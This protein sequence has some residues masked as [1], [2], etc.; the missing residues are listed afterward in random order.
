MIIANKNVLSAIIIFE[1]FFSD[2]FR[3]YDYGKIGNMKHY[4]SKTPPNYDLSQ[5]TAATYIYHSKYD[6]IAPPKV[7]NNL[8]YTSS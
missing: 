8:K 4:Q 2:Y 3:K 5:V 7:R 6:V 1:Q